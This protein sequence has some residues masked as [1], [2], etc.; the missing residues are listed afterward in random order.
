MATT[1]EA[2]V[3][4]LE[5]YGTDTV[6]GIPGVHTLEIY[7][8][9]APV[10]RSATSRRG[11]SR[12]RGSWPTRGRAIAG[13][14]GVCVLITG[15]GRDQRADADRPGLPRLDPDARDLVRAP[16]PRRGGHVGPIHDLPDQQRAHAQ[17]SRPSRATVADPAELPDAFAR[18]FEVFESR[19]PRPVHI[20]VPIDVLRPAGARASRPP[21]GGGVRR[22][23]TA[24]AVDAAAAALAAR[25]RRP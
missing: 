14:P 25:R 8:G 11:T 15:A 18:A 23:P 2:V 9:L 10:R 7:R 19:R 16:L 13:S 3:R 5:Q 24:A 4:L 1:G 17:P 6:F 21:R 20:G 12:A 22:S